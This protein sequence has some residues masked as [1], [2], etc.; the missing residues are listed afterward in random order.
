MA[1]LINTNTN[2]EH[3]FGNIHDLTLRCDGGNIFHVNRAILMEASPVWRAML[4]GPFMEGE[5]NSVH[6]HE[7]DPD[8]MRCVISLLYEGMSDGESLPPGEN[9]NLRTSS[10]L[11]KDRR[12][13]VVIDKYELAGLRSIIQSHRE[14]SQKLRSQELATSEQVTQEQRK[15]ASLTAELKREQMKPGNLV[16]IR[17]RPP[18]G[19]R[20]QEN[21]C[22]LVRRA[23][24]S[25]VI[26]ANDEDGGTEIGVNWDNGGESH[27][28]HCGKKNGWALKYL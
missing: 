22:E 12:L 2:A 6:L 9:A 17:H 26:I 25:G 1:E 24:L 13:D 23:P 21:L 11:H 16:E 10:K 14:Q 5:E 8:A 15:V 19:T 27:N 18:L 28:L 3:F 4:G 7:D 20:V